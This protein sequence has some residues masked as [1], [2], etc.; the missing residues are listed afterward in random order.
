MKEVKVDWIEKYIPTLSD[1]T[2][3]S[4][5]FAWATIPKNDVFPQVCRFQTCRE[6]FIDIF[7]NLVHPS[8]SYGYSRK[9]DRRR[10][11]IIVGRQYSRITTESN[12]LK[13]MVD[14][15]EWMIRACRVLNKF[16]KRLKW[17]LTKLY[18]VEQLPILTERRVGAYVFTANSKWMHSPQLM[19]LYLLILRLCRFKAWDDFKKATPE[20]LKEVYKKLKSVRC[21]SNSQMFSDKSFMRHSYEYWFTMLDNVDELFLNRDI[22]TIY[23]TNH[24]HYGIQSLVKDSAD[25]VTLER[26]DKMCEAER[27]AAES[28]AAN[29][30]AKKEQTSS[31]SSK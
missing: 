30:M 22:S 3:A 4:V 23:K 13:H 29:E 14:N 15:D 11:R 8:N 17:T 25:R 19:S 12:F 26:W 28:A 27:E 1:Y 16:E 10:T 20:N 6:T 21:G 24:A 18:K 7:R 2:S 9:I 31:A 5:M